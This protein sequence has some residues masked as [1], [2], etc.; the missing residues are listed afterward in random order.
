MDKTK[1]K[2]KLP[3]GWVWTTIGEIGIVQSGG[4]PSTRNNEFWGGEIAWI[5]PADL[6]GYN[7]KFISNGKRNITQA[8]LDYSSAKL[9]PEGSICFSSRAPIGYTVITKN[10]LATNQGFKNLIP[11]KSLNS[12][13]AYYYFKTL[14]SKA[15]KVASGTTFLELSATKFSQ[16]PF[17]LPPLTEQKKIVSKLETL[18]SELEQA[19]KSLQK[20]KQELEFYRQAILKSAFDGKLTEKWRITSQPEQAMELLNQ[21]ILQREKEYKNQVEKWE[22]EKL[23]LKN[24]NIIG[25]RPSKPTRN[26]KIIEFEKE[27]LTNLYQ[28]PQTWKW[29]KIGNFSFVT[30]L[31]GFEFSKYIK[32]LEKGDIPVIKAQNIGK[33]SFKEGNFSFVD[34]ATLDK[35]PRISL[36][37][38]ELLFVFIGANIGNV[39]I[40]PSNKKY[41]LGPNVAM[42]RLPLEISNKY[43]MYFLSSLIG[44]KNIALFTQS[45]AQGS[46]SMGSIRKITIP[47]PS[48]EEQNQIVK[49]LE[50]HFTLI[51]HLEKSIDNCLS[52]STIL[53]HSILKKAF[54]GKLVNQDSNDESAKE[55]LLKIKSE[56]EIYLKAQKELDKLKPKKKRQM[57][58]KKSVLEILKESNTPIS[59]QELW[60]NSVHEGD[61]E[62]F[63]GELKKIHSRLI[64]VKENTESLL[65]LKK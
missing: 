53:K 11:T 55:L 46:I 59:T 56:K 10:K 58:T 14:K 57:E 18:F 15:E 64:E 29:G 51:E 12:E 50:S 63:Y 8:G 19:E 42:I 24:T 32:Y 28:L 39:G 40:A 20:V 30:K 3:Q 41:L 36:K 45:S 16:L 61:I 35:V 33:Y 49:I 5:T 25:K 13:Y 1:A 54:N 44:K 52:D 23:R 65:S 48:S 38:G 43:I 6:S 22:E 37:G 47:I 2:Y 7:N 4:T 26:Q 21:I 34:S 27:E 9:L 62:S 31:A 17:P 60:T